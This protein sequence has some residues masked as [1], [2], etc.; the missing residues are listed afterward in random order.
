MQQAQRLLF[1]CTG[2]ICR[3]PTA[4]AVLRRKAEIQRWGRLLQ[5]DSAGTH[6]Y[7][8]GDSPDSRSCEIA[9][10]SGYALDHLVGR[11]V[12]AADFEQFDLLLAM[13]QGHETNLRQRA[14]SEFQHKISLFL[15]YAGIA[16]PRE[17][18]DPYYGTLA[19]FKTTLELIERGCDALLERLAREQGW[20]RTA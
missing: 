12:E 1:V 8:V 6:D 13:D 15:P 3:S 14:P 10:H 18:A 4:E 2:N 16:T 5:I 20:Q 7:H 11:M 19:G 9:R 17:V